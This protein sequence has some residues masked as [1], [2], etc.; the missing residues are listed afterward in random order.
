MIEERVKA[1]VVTNS[2]SDRLLSMHDQL[3]LE[4]GLDSLSFVELML[5][6]EKEF[7][8]KI[9]MSEYPIIITVGDLVEVVKGKL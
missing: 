2:K 5:A 6:V 8:I 1:I 7:G 4:V 3:R 9:S